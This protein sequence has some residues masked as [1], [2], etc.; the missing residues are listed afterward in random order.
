LHNPQQATILLGQA[1]EID[2]GNSFGWERLGTAALAMDND[3]LVMQATE[4][5]LALSPDEVR[6]LTARA[7][8]LLKGK[9]PLEAIPFLERAVALG[10][11]WAL[12]ALLPIV[13]AG[14]Y[15]FTP[16]RPR[17]EKICQSAIDALQPSGFACMGGLNYFG[18]GRPADKPKALQWFA[19]AADRGVTVAMMDAALMLWS[20]DGVP[21]DRQRAIGYWAKARLAGEPR[22]DVQLRANLS[23]WEYWQKIDLPDYQAM[24]V[25]ILGKR[26]LAAA[27]LIGILVP[28]AGLVLLGFF[29]LR[30]KPA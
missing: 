4:R 3:D 7:S 25:Q 12:Q 18:M 20:G 29:F 9:S 27:V 23:D 26:G 13:A 22:A 11:E 17:A 24:A 28:I 5:A 6:P 8:V 14:K 1:L 19:E 10:S 2:P 16:D 15:G 21:K 30:R